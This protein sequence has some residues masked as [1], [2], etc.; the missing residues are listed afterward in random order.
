MHAGNTFL[1]DALDLLEHVGVFLID[2]VGEV[3]SIVQDLKGRGVK[4][5]AIQLPNRYFFFK[6]LFPVHP[7]NPM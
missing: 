7:L 6:R 4:L 2:P 5:K 1:D 3:P